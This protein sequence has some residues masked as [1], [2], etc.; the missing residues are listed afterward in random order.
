MNKSGSLLAKERPWG[1]R[2]IGHLSVRSRTNPLIFA[3]FQGSKFI[4]QNSYYLIDWNSLSNVQW[5]PIEIELSDNV[6][7]LSEFLVV[8]FSFIRPLPTSITPRN[9]CGQSNYSYFFHF[10]LLEIRIF[11]LRPTLVE[12]HAKNSMPTTKIGH[13]RFIIHPLAPGKNLPQLYRGS[14]IRPN[15][16]GSQKIFEISH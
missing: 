10:T 12:H 1:T 4:P 5:P 9:R 3:L 15:V 11:K 13:E 6:I 2:K 14:N 7:K 8:S 16:Q